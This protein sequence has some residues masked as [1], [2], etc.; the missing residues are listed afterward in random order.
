M[1]EVSD[2]VFAYVQPDGGWCVNNAGLVVGGTT[3]AVIDTVATEQ[4]ARRLCEEV[5]RYAP[6]PPRMLVNTH[7]HGDH[8]FG[9]WLFGPDITVVAHDLARAEM[10]RSG[11]ALRAVWP[12][13]DWGE[14]H[15]ALPSI[16][17][18]DRLTLHLGEVELQLIHVGP[19]HTTNDVVVWLG[20]RGVLFAGDVVLSGCTPFVHM[21]SLEGS[22]RAVARLRALR[23]RT[24]VCGH[25]PVC[26]PEVLDT[27]ERY[28]RWVRDLAR[29]GSAAGLSPLETALEADLGEFGALR[30]PE[31]L[32]ANL[33]RAY[34]ELH[35]T[36]ALG[37][38]LPSA[39]AFRD[40]AIWNGGRVPTCLA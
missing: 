3:A 33:A 13:V 22:L 6:V 24:I 31:R 38:H 5:T 17:F 4:R 34:R 26:G 27:T 15:L 19:A 9:N 35:G 11:L 21:G 32:V 39:P 37:A 1:A 2:S 40:M 23:P 30:D 10:A 16:T 12:D 28:L 20:D 7:H 18:T 25:G 14:T 8:T 36:E 29:A